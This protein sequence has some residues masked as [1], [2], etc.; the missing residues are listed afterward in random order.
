MELYG[1]KD[2]PIH[3][4]YNLQSTD[5]E[6]KYLGHGASNDFTPLIASSPNRQR[7]EK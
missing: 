6:E 5:D 3:D 1:R 4:E 7:S 2:K